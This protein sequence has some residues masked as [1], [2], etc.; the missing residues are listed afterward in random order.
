MRHPHLLDSFHHGRRPAQ[1][2]IERALST[3]NLIPG[4]LIVLSLVAITINTGSHSPLIPYQIQISVPSG[5][6]TPYVTVFQIQQNSTDPSPWLLAPA[7]DKTVWIVTEGS[8]KHPFSQLVNFTVGSGFE[9]VATL[10]NSFPSDVVYDSITTD[11][12]RR[13]W[14]LENNSLAY[15]NAISRNITVAATFPGSPWYM[16]IDHND[17]FWITLTGPDQIVEYHP[18]GNP[19]FHN[20][21]N[22]CAETTYGCGLQGIVLDP[23]DDSLWFAELYAGR[24]GHMVCNSSTQ[25]SMTDYGPPSGIDT[26][27]LIQLTVD[28]N[29]L[30]WFTLH[31]GNEFGNF[32]PT[33][34]EWR[35]FPIGYCPDS[36]V[37]GC[38]T[39]LPNAIFL[40]SRG[41]VWFSEHIAGRIATIAPNNESD[42][43]R[44]GTLVEYNLPTYSA[45]CPRRCVPLTWWMR[46]GPNDLIWFG[47]YELGEIGFV[48]ATV[49]IPFSV[50]SSSEV[51]VVQGESVQI[52]VS[53]SFVGNVPHLNVSTSRS[54]ITADPPMLS[55][56]I[57]RQMISKGVDSSNLT[58]TLSASW[59][60]TLESRYVAVS[61][62]DGNVTVNT[63]VK[64]DVLP[65]LVA[66]STV[67]LAAGISAF[68]L[69][70]AGLTLVPALRKRKK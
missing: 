19:V 55:W 17:H 36:Y 20:I 24:I 48:N 65:S 49:P 68:S 56:S 58:I 10:P 39:G 50:R 33:T 37:N 12:S 63:F 27:G 53:I 69:I 66:Y 8:G 30:I 23:K 34:G 35:I 40:D 38:A 47:A 44:Y 26:L 16:T 42:A 2:K 1:R 57:G 45:T 46:P 3:R 6:T 51:S 29:G 7:S 67:G 9:V 59:S 64:V 11:N 62:Y 60:S 54:D 22:T 28:R 14:I 70:S 52:P 43:Q 41:Q 4:M 61:A 31:T 21:T 13:V 25:C 15:Y 32:K 5:P 18:G